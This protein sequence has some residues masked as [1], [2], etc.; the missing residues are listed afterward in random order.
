[1]HKLNLVHWGWWMPVWLSLAA[2]SSSDTAQKQASEANKG[3]KLYE[4]VL[5]KTPLERMVDGTIEA[6]NQATVSAQTSGRVVEL[7]YDVND[8]VPA[9]AVI[10]RLR[11]TEQRAGLQQAQAALQ[12]AMTR[13]AEAKRQFTRI[14]GLYKEKVA[15]K[16][17]FDNALANRDAASARLEAARAASTSAQEGLA[18]TEVRAPY[19]GIVTKRLVQVGETVQPGT[20]LMSGVSLQYLRVN[21]DLPQSIVEKVRTIKKAAIYVVDKRVEANSF[22]VFPEADSHTH[23]FHARANLPADATDLHPGMFVKVGLMVGE[24]ERLL[25]PESALVTRSEVMGAYVVDQT[26]Q[27][28]LRQLRIGEHIGQRVEVLAG[29]SVGDKVVLNPMHL[30]QLAGQ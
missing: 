6:I 18:Y 19:A 27:R 16:Q 2:C 23:T 4:M 17:E 9:G 15:T 25:I 11:A 21:F 20:P 24:V 14:E 1:M 30:A 26:G 8:F 12:E 3:L 28:R 29:L 13:E 10:M 22:T 5:E 7:F